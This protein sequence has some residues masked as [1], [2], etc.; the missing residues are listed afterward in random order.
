MDRFGL[1]TLSNVCYS[2]NGTIHQLRHCEVK[3][4]DEDKGHCYAGTMKQF[5]TGEHYRVLFGLVLFTALLSVPVVPVGAIAGFG[6][7][8]DGRYFSDPVQWS[9][10]NDITG[11]DGTCFSPDTVVTR[12]EAALWMWRM[13]DPSIA[14]QHSFVDVLD[15]KLQQP[16]SW[17]A[18]TGITTGTSDTT[19]SPGGPLTRAQAATF[20]WRLAGKPTAGSHPFVD[21]VKGWQQQPV[22][23][24]A[25]EGITTGTSANEFSPDSPLTR[26][27]FITFLYRYDNTPAVTV[28]PAT[29]ICEPDTFAAISTGGGHS[30]GIRTNGTVTCWG[31]NDQGEA[32]APDGYFSAISAGS[33]H[34]CGI[35]TSG[36]LS[37]WG[38]ASFERLNAPDGTFVAINA[39]SGHSCAI[40]SDQTIACW[41]ENVAGRTNAPSGTYIA[42]AVGSFH[43]CA[44]RTDQTVRCW[45]ANDANDRSHGSRLG[46]G[47]ANP[48][49][50][51]FTA[52]SLGSHHSCGIRTNGSVACWGGIGLGQ[53][54][55]PDGQFAAFSVGGSH[56][57]GIRTDGGVA[58]WGGNSLG[59]ADAPDGTF[60]A[61]DAG[62][63]HSC[64]IR[65]NGTVMCWVV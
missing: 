30:C 2:S 52:I 35:Q 15:A 22:A 17:M 13:K 41:G 53:A 29:P 32:D 57:C 27:Q 38:N 65:T 61:I 49:S 33:I 12:G 51:S 50:G 10:N 42:V 48:P 16:V 4:G 62:G 19:F 21:V 25:V 18:A 26:A 5:A 47:Q 64:G 20:L 9:V 45:G 40:R 6:D 60:T 44:I 24:M 39:G 36:T 7:V 63:G 1:Q 58:C 37:C 23:W 46:F 56:S 55:A 31:H 43:S 59:Q 11:I 54:D 28:D 14:P 34:S 8:E 3:A